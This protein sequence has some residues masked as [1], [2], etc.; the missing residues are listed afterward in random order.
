MVAKHAM[1][2]IETTSHFVAA[3]LLKLQRNS[4]FLLQIMVDTK[5]QTKSQYVRMKGT[6]SHNDGKDGTPSCA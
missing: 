3:S 1:D 6:R 2:D 4:G 5:A